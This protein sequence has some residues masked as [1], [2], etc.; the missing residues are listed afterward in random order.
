MN[1]PAPVQD[2]PGWDENAE[3]D[4]GPPHAVATEHGRF[5]SDPGTGVLLRSVTNA[6]DQLAKEGLPQG[7]ATFTTD[8][9]I[10]RLPELLRAAR[11]P[12]DLAA[13]RK[14]ASFAY[15][16][17]WERRAELGSRTH[18]QVEARNLGAPIAPDPEVEPFLDSYVRWLSDF[19][20]NLGTPGGPSDIKAA[21]CTVLNR[22][23][24]YGGTSD[25]WVHLRFPSPTSPLVPK[26]RPRKV[27]ANPL[28][29]PSG[30]WLVD[31]KTSIKYPAS[32]MRESFPMQLAALRRAEV[33]L[34][35]PPE[36]RYGAAEGHDA[37]HEHPVPPFA[38]VAILNLRTDAYGFIPLTAAPDEEE[39]RAFDAFL[40]LHPV[41]DY[42][43]DLDLRPYKPIQ[44]PTRR[45]AA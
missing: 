12:D 11:D 16:E 20:V 14:K 34:I 23:L 32:L 38:G 17:E 19:G 15:K 45:D 3:V 18:R 10:N 7:A 36:C 33:A 29:T 28:P 6:I 25:L 31:V 43:D 40:G 41:S 37:S 39:Q 8:Y 4:L 2:L 26:H 35:C 9:M 44:P 21:E 24:G 42:V 30:L 13:F 22:S 1:A 27:P 5:Y